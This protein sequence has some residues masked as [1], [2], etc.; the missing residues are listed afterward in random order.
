MRGRAHRI[1]GFKGHG[2]LAQ[3]INYLSGPPHKIAGGEISGVQNRLQGG[4]C[5]PFV[6]RQD[7]SSIKW[8]RDTQAMPGFGVVD[9]APDTGH[10]FQGFTHRATGQPR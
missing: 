8:P 3:H 2:Y 10:L 9:H 4:P 1:I 6:H 7:K 5:C